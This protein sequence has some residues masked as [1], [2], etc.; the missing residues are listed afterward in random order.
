MQHKLRC[1]I[2]RQFAALILAGPPVGRGLRSSET[3]CPPHHKP[4]G[5]RRKADMLF[6]RRIRLTGPAPSP[7]QGSLTP[8]ASLKAGFPW[9]Y[10]LISAPGATKG[11][12]NNSTKPS[13]HRLPAAQQCAIINPAKAVQVGLSEHEVFQR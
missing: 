7:K 13:G 6:P 10:P 2:A 4:R 12:V 5:T 1:F 11:V 9:R 3:Y 8:Q